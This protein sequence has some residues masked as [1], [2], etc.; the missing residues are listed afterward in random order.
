MKKALLLGLVFL[1]SCSTVKPVYVKDGV[2]VYRATCNGLIRDIS[3][4]Y[5]K[6]S[7]Q[8][9]GKF[10]VINSIENEYDN[11]SFTNDTKRTVYQGNTKITTTEPAF[12]FGGNKIINRSLFF[13]CK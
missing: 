1:A 4:C 2:Q 11:V 5:A 13:Y 3:D 6:A 10:E 8:C 12:S 7:E 9:A